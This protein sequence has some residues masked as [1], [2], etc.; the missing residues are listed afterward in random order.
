MKYIA[1][2][3]LTVLGTAFGQ[4]KQVEIIDPVL[5]MKAYSFTIPAKWIFE[6]VVMQGSPCSSGASPIFRIVSPDGIA[7]VKMLPRLDWTWSTQPRSLANSNSSGCL[8]FDKEISANDFLKYMVGLLG[9]TFIKELPTPSLALL[10]ENNRKQN[11]QAI[12]TT[13]PGSAPFLVKSDMAAFLVHYNINSIP[14]EEN[15]SVSTL[16]SDFPSRP[17]AGMKVVHTYTCNAWVMRQRARQGQL[18]VMN[19]AFS[20]ISKS[21]AID[22]QWNQRWQAVMNQKIADMSAASTRAIL[23]KGDENARRMQMQHNA[24]MQGQEMRQSQH[25][26]FLASMKRGTD[27]S[28]RRTQESMNTR[29]RMAQDWADYALDQ[30][31]RRDPRTGE[32]TK[33]SSSYTYTWVNESGQRMQTN[34]VNDNPNGRVNGNWTL[35]QNVR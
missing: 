35:Q 27:L 31:K 23:A 3:T 1:W 18:D 16:C 7:E 8:P 29:G 24:F 6:G 17:P 12:A 19:D 10:H 33:D 14:V 26:Q 32:I 11:Q 28:M 5:Q 21:M 22:Q 2:I 15:L 34:D 25:E 4:T 20:G 30:Q 13:P 9:V